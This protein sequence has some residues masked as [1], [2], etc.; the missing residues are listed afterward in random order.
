[1]D[2]VSCWTESDLKVDY[3][4]PVL[5]T[6]LC[7]GKSGCWGS[8]LWIATLVCEMSTKTLVQ[9]CEIQVYFIALWLGVGVDSWIGP[10]LS[11][12]LDWF[13]FYSNIH[14]VLD[15]DYS[16]RL[17]LIIQSRL[18][19]FVGNGKYGTS[20]CI[21]N[22]KCFQMHFSMGQSVHYI[23]PWGMARETEAC[24]YLYVTLLQSFWYWKGSKAAVCLMK[25]SY[26]FTCSSQPHF[27]KTKPTPR[28]R[29]PIA[30]SVPPIRVGVLRE[31]FYLIFWQCRTV[32]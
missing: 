20:H 32:I 27:H 17:A 26:V 31:S 22:C 11:C 25:E 24:A 12:H 3:H 30:F 28:E 18:S 5:N 8:L 14:L 15:V 10:N 21:W 6:V 29:N 1:M 19:S 9:C 16:T 2:C 13:P 4:H 7:Q 23:W